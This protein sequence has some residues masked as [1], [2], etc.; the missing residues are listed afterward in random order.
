MN[1]LLIVVGVLLMLLGIILGIPAVVEL[2]KAGTIKTGKEEIAA[3]SRFQIYGFW[4]LI[5]VIV[6]VLI[7]V[8]KC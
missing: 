5:L 6:G 2:K 8:I 1:T 7:L 3:E 4:P